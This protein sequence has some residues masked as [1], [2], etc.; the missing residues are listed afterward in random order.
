MCVVISEITGRRGPFHFGVLFSLP[1]SLG[2]FKALLYA[3][4]FTCCEQ[5]GLH[6]GVVEF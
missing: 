5:K 1:C 6:G 2:S 4:T 3:H